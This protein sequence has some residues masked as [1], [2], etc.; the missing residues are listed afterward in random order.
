MKISS[1]LAIV[2]LVLVTFADAGATS[3]DEGGAQPVAAAHERLA[4]A[5]A[6]LAKAAQR[7]EKDPPSTAD[8]DAAHA[9]V[10]ALKD[11]ID[12]GAE[13]E[14]KDLDYAKAVL[15]ARRE[16]RKQREYVDQR[17][18]SVQ[19]HDL[20]GAIDP[21]LANLSDRVRRVEGKEASA[22]DFDE[23][24]VAAEAL[25]KTVAEAR[26]FAKQDQKFAIYIAEVDATL[27]RHE[28]AIDDRW[29]LLSVD[30]HRVLVN[31]SRQG[32]S[33][34]IAA[35]GK[36]GS[37]AQFE[38]AEKGIT[39]LSKRLEEGKVLET[40]DMTYRSDA[41]RARTEVAQARKRIDEVWSEKGLARLKSE[42]EPA[43]E[44]LAAAAKAVRTRKPTVDQL[45][46]AR[47]AA[48]VVRK[49]LEKFQPQAARNQAFGQYVSEVKKTL[50][51]VEVELQRRGLDLARADL[52]QALR[53]IEK[54]A[55][56]DE[57]FEEAKTALMILEKTLETVHTRD[58]TM[59]RP[60]ADA[61]NLLGTTR[62][63]M[64]KRRLEVD[65]QRQ[66]TKV[67]EARRHAA[68]LI[69]Q[70]HSA[71]AG[72]D[73]V[74]EAENA[75]QQLLA[76]LDESAALT[77][78]DRE[79]A[80]YHRQVKERVA[81][82]DKR[83]ASRK[84]ALAVGEARTALNEAFTVAKSKVEAAKQPEATDPDVAAASQSINGVNR[85]LEAHASLEKQD[86]GYAAHAAKAREQLDRLQEAGDFAKQARALRRRTVEALSAGASAADSAEAA[87]NLR[88]QKEQYE[89]AI[90]HFRSCEEAG[91]SMIEENRALAGAVM[92]VDGR[93]STAKDVIALCNQRLQATEQSMKQV[94]ALIRFEEGPKRSFETGKVL[95]AQAKKSEALSQFDECIATGM[96]LQNRNPELKDRKFEVEGTS[97]TL[98]DVLQQC[99]TQRKP[100]R[101][102]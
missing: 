1:T 63:A 10:G 102:K 34:S 39:L 53:N 86:K 67:E 27:A 83:I 33:A 88:A 13:N 9:A 54:R 21:A 31:E 66:R 90:A 96:I 71:N 42:I 36:G 23:A 52:V 38:A 82:M 89:K 8:L 73:G 75:I 50:V 95:L 46:E 78:K 47:T 65:V 22:K 56:T 11:A 84:V 98:S 43:H 25:R 24:R 48:I 12:A 17:R 4:A 58:E 68:E 28:K 26:P 2:S 20:R 16:L 81:E 19:L 101:V 72:N 57:H 40:K 91:A 3:P 61:R 45:A 100:L 30:K 7:L 87:Q 80:L 41:D 93:P 29:T 6:N 64:A 92:L 59:I 60:V 32:L 55:P 76:V 37:D 35:L 69:A 97:M 79:F 85:A 5:Q 70:A 14:S 62:T 77:R 15:A 51:E 49:L 94:V 44:E 99:V 18:A 74:K